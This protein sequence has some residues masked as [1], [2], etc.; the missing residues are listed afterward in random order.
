ELVAIAD[1]DQPGIVLGAAVAKGKQLFEH[2]ADVDAVER[3]Q[4][5]QLQR[6]LAHRQRLFLSRPGRRRVDAGELAARRR[7]VR[8]D[9]RRNVGSGVSHGN[10]HERLVE[11]VR[12]QRAV[13]PI[14]RRSL[15]V[16]VSRP[17]SWITSG[18]PDSGILGRQT[19][20]IRH[21]TS[22]DHSASE[23]G[24]LARTII[25]RGAVPIPGQA[26]ARTSLLTWRGTRLRNLSTGH[27][28]CG[29]GG[30]GEQSAGAIR[31]PVWVK[32]G[33]V[34]WPAPC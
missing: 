7:I 16:T 1:L 26:L 5:I 23:S 2:D 13:R 24:K 27:R 12:L 14:I 8:P 4:G 6:V 11:K 9:L 33:G 34:S 32:P 28:F 3:G 20:E 25:A 31:A 18:R 10:P 21:L 15:R 19:A 22:F 17:P 30:R 29:A